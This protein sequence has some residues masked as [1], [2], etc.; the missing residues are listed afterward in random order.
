MP[1]RVDYV[2]DPYVVNVVFDKYNIWEIILIV[3]YIWEVIK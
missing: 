3:E 2:L 1:H